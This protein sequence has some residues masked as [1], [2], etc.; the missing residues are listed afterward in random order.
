MEEQDKCNEIRTGAPQQA[1]NNTAVADPV[2]YC[3]NSASV[4]ESKEGLHAD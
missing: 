1:D 4:L 2:N 3:K